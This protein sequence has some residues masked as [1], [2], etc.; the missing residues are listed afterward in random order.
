MIFLKKISHTCIH[1]LYYCSIFCPLIDGMLSGAPQTIDISR[2]VKVTLMTSN[3]VAD[4]AL[5][6]SMICVLQKLFKIY[7]KYSIA[8]APG[9]ECFITQRDN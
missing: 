8:S 5:V 6:Q 4:Y 7:L 9:G 3:Y 2:C 1:V